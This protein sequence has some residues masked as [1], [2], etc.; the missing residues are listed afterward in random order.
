VDE[1]TANAGI[2]NE[3]SDKALWSGP[4]LSPAER[5]VET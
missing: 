2:L 5:S 4:A 3:M 1:M